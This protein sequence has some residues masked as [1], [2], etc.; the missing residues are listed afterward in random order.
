MSLLV[1]P[2]DTTRSIPSSHDHEISF[3]TLSTLWESGKFTFKNVFT[4]QFPFLEPMI[5]SIIYH[6]VHL[7]TF[8]VRY[9]GLSL[10]GDGLVI[11]TCASCCHLVLLLWGSGQLNLRSKF[12]TVYTYL[13]EVAC[14]ACRGLNLPLECCRTSQQWIK[15][16]AQWCIKQWL[17]FDIGLVSVVWHVVWHQI[18]SQFSVIQHVIWQ[19]GMCSPWC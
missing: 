1:K 7:G 2:H 16:C 8:N 17:V 5:Q 3:L 18:S 11:S 4:L 6:P 15:I 19:A 9:K 13:G 12:H 14:D 10:L